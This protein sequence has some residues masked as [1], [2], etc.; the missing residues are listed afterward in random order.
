MT[1][2]PSRTALVVVADAADEALAPWRRRFHA[3]SVERGIPA[4]L[5]ILFPFVPAARVDAD[6]LAS[7]RALYAPVHAV[8]VRARPVESFPGVAW[9]APEPAAPFL[10][11]IAATRA[12]FPDPPPYGDPTLEPVP[13]CTVGGDRA[14]GRRRTLAAMLAE[15]RDG[16]ARPAARVSRRGR[17]AARRAGRRHL[18]R[19]DRRSRSRATWREP[20]PTHLRAGPGRRRRAAARAA[21]RPRPRRARG[22][23]ARRRRRRALGLRP[24]RRGRAAARASSPMRRS[25]TSPTGWEDAWRAFHHPVEAGGLWIGPPWEMPPDGGALGRDRPR[26]RVRD[27]RPS[28]D[29]ALRRAARRRGAARL[30]A[31]RRL[32][33]GCPLDRG[34]APRLRPRARARQ[35]RGRGRDDARERRA[36]GVAVEAASPTRSPTRCRRPTSRSRTSCSAPVEAILAPARRRRGDHLRLPRTERPR[37]RLDERRP[38]RA[39]RLGGRSPRSASGLQT[40]RPIRPSKLLGSHGDLLD[41]VPRLQ[42]LVRRRAG[43]PRAAARGRPRRGR[44]GGEIQVVNTLLRHPRGRLEVA[45][46]GSAGGAHGAHGLRDGLRVEPRGRVRRRCR[47]NVVVTA[48]TGRGG[49]GVRRRRRRRDRLRRRRAPPRP[50]FAPS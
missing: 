48:R 3:W 31:R 5:T 41:A 34:G 24:H 35:R 47:A 9:L 4:H 15:L 6:L 38:A 45:A 43:D 12:A 23:G 28:D 10:E 42:G 20:L 40:D 49:R 14:T 2:E 11:L 1:G 36:N 39:R 25:R 32:R 19:G 18:G 33:L 29:A 44:D 8:R 27:R 26:P 22:A 50:V 17:D 30:P 21:A 13:H 37:P 7:L 16:L 46:G